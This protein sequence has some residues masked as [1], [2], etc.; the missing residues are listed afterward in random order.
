MVHDFLFISLS[1]AIGEQ[2]YT[3]DQI[4]LFFFWMPCKIVTP[5]PDGTPA[6]QLEVLIRQPAPQKKKEENK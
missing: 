5:L 2:R 4:F 1:H 3:P 6:Q